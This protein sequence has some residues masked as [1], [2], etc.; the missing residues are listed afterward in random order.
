MGRGWN[1]KEITWKVDKNGCW[2][3]ISHKGEYPIKWY[4]G[5]QHPVSHIMY[6]KYIGPI[7][8]GLWVLHHCDNTKC[9]NPGHLF[10]GT[11]QDNIID[12]IKKVEIEK[13]LEKKMADQKLQ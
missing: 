2:I 8:K 10:L 7:P 12:M 4:K 3:C 6:E 9:I 1:R 5:R 13:P 11:N